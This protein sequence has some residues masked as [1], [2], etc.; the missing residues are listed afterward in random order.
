MNISLTGEA[1]AER[2][3]QEYR[4]IS[5]GPRSAALPPRVGASLRSLKSDRRSLSLNPDWLPGDSASPGPDEYISSRILE[6]IDRRSHRFH[7]VPISTEPETV[8]TLAFDSERT[9]EIGFVPRFSRA[10]SR[11][12]PGSEMG[13]DPNDQAHQDRQGDAV[14]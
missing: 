5:E 8:G 13:V 2:A 10:V 3:G 1:G 9:Y 12:H 4:T 14:P 7:A 11:H 6:M